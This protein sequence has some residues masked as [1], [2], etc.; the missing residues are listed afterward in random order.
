D[1]IAIPHVADPILRDV[2][3]PC[4]TLCLLRGAVD[5]DAVDGKPV[6]ALFTVVSANVPG[7][8]RIL[9]QLGFLLHD[10]ELR[11]LLGERAPG[12]DLLA[13]VRVVEGRASGASL[14]ASQGPS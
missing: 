10:E 6:H 1:G 9:G 4:V 13:R 2:T 5:F 11:R 14:S 8:L 7:H 3:A 12:A